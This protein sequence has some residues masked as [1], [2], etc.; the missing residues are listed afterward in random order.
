[1]TL[2]ENAV[3]KVVA[4]K[5][6]DEAIRVVINST[7]RDKIIETVSQSIAFELADS[8]SELGLSEWR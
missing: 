2:Y 6:T 8:F 3:D 4:E 5:V 7:D 1:M